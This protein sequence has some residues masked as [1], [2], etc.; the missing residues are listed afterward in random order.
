MET[1]FGLKSLMTYHQGIT[2]LGPG[3]DG[4]SVITN[5]ILNHD[6]VLQ[7]TTDHGKL[8]ISLD[9]KQRELLAVQLQPTV[10]KILIRN[11]YAT[12]R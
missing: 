4:E 11:M 8:Y 9:E 3:H 6:G 7:F 12:A 1:R 2:Y 10:S 5:I